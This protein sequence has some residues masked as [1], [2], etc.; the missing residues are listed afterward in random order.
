MSS[1]TQSARLSNAS[2]QMQASL[3]QGLLEP[4]RIQHRTCLVCHDT[5]IPQ[6]STPEAR[7]HPCIN[8]ICVNC[9]QR[10]LSDP[11]KDPECWRC[12][13]RFDEF[14]D[15]ITYVGEEAYHRYLDRLTRQVLRK[16]EKDRFVECHRAEC[17][18]A[19]L[20]DCGEGSI[21]E[22][23]VC[24]A[25]TCSFCKSPAHAGES[26]TEFQIR[27]QNAQE[28]SVFGEQ[29]TRREQSDTDDDTESKIQRCPNSECGTLLQR[30]NGCMHVTCGERL[31]PPKRNYAKLNFAGQCV[32]EFCFECLETHPS[33]LPGCGGDH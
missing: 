22:C 7:K 14:K 21:V 2:F 5:V 30:N 20:Q 25:K 3:Q 9:R 16:E 24:H 28:Q 19:V 1:R 6:L 32:Y 31:L 10:A 23:E 13:F 15:L 29:A 18:W 12:N 26:C 11:N 33:H 27:T 8:V 17:S 4:A